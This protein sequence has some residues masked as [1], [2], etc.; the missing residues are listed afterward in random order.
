MTYHSS[1]TARL[2]DNET[3]ALESYLSGHWPDA[4]SSPLLVTEGYEFHQTSLPGSDHAWVL[5]VGRSGLYERIADAAL[6][7]KS[8]RRKLRALYFPGATPSQE[9]LH[10]SCLYFDEIF[11]ISPGSSVFENRRHPYGDSDE[12][13]VRLYHEHEHAFIER[14]RE[15]DRAALPLKQAGILRPLLPQCSATVISLRS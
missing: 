10:Q 12:N 13:G 9:L 15:F 1:S 4:L 5:V 8:R 6:R 3:Q 14:I 7:T 2:T 11:Y